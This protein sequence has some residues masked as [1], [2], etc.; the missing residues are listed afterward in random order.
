M[1]ERSIEAI[2]PPKSDRKNPASCDMEIYKRRHLVEKKFQKLKEFKRVAMHA[3]KTDTS[4]EA[5]IHIGATIIRT[6]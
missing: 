3:C 5:M 1:A 2:I 6:R 4:F